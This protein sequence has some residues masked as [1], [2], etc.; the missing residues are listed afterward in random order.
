MAQSPKV[1]LGTFEK[2]YLSDNPQTK[3]YALAGIR[4]L[5]KAKF[6]EL[7]LSLH[8]SPLK[9]QI[10]EGCIGSVHSIEDIADRLDSGKYDYW[11]K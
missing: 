6:N 8:A 7:K 5:D 9:V 3:A 2:L 10:E 4:K 1:A 11:I